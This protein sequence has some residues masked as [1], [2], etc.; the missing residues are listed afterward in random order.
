[1]AIKNNKATKKTEFALWLFQ[2]DI[3]QSE[4]ARRTQL[5]LGC[6]HKL[7]KHGIAS[8]AT[9]NLVSHELNIDLDELKEMVDNDLNA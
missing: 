3:T 6:I 7:V 5:S 8:K 4:L 9:L 2:N 1:M